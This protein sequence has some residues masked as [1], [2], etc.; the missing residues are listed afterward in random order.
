M[1]NPTSIM[2]GHLREQ[3]IVFTQIACLVCWLNVLFRMATSTGKRNNM[4]KMQ[5]LMR[6]DSLLADMADPSITF[7][8]VPIANLANGCLFSSG[9]VA[10]RL[11]KFSQRVRLAPRLTVLSILFTM[12]GVVLSA[13]LSITFQIGSIMLILLMPLP[14]ILF[15][16]FAMG[17][18]IILQVSSR[19]F[20]VSMV[21]FSAMLTYLFLVRLTSLTLLLRSLLT[22]GSM[23]FSMFLLQL[24]LVSSVILSIVLQS[25]FTISGIFSIGSSSLL[26][27]TELTPSTVF[28]AV[29][30]KLIQKLLFAAGKANFRGKQG[31]LNAVIYLWHSCHPFN[32]GG[33]LEA[34]LCYQHLAVSSRF[35]AIIA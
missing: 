11:F 29:F 19:L 12:G 24:R 15:Q 33:S 1:L 30:T 7:K 14:C 28:I 18:I 21:I 8:N 5:F 17:S 27:A 32:Q 22:M 31:Q 26:I 34:A 3:S 2:I 25:P 23:I 13:S 4:V 35:D 9:H 10:H 20:P 16:L 6:Q